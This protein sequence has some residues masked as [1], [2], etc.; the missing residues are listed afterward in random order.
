MDMKLKCVLLAI[1][2]TLLLSA[3][4]TSNKVSKFTSANIELGMSQSDFVAKFGNPFN[5]ELSYT[6]D[7]HKREK[8]FYKEEIFRGYW[9]LVTTAFTFVDSKLTNQ[10]IVKEDRVYPATNHKG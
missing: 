8:L 2:S 7:N 6:Q 4:Y 9:Q 5:K 10:E 3:C 1:F